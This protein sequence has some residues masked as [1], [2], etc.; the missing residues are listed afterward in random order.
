MYHDYAYKR[1]ADRGAYP[2]FYYSRADEALIDQ[3]ANSTSFTGRVANG[4]FRLKRTFAPKLSESYEDPP[5]KKRKMRQV[6]D[7]LPSNVP[8]GFFPQ[9]E[10]K[11]N[12]P[13]GPVQTGMA[14]PDSRVHSLSIKGWNKPPP[15]NW[16]GP[17]RNH[18]RVVDNMVTTNLAQVAYYG[19]TFLGLDQQRQYIQRVPITIW[20]DEAG[21]ATMSN[22][23]ANYNAANIAAAGTSGKGKTMWY[24]SEKSTIEYR[25]NSETP[26]RFDIA[27]FNYKVASSVTVDQLVLRGTEQWYNTVTPTTPYSTDPKVVLWH[28]PLQ[29][30]GKTVVKKS[31]QATRYVLPG[32]SMLIRVSLGFY[33]D[34]TNQANLLSTF[35][36]GTG[37]MLVRMEG[38]LGHLEDPPGTFITALKAINA[39]DIERETFNKFWKKETVIRDFSL[40]TFDVAPMEVDVEVVN[41]FGEMKEQ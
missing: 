6:D 33:N 25:N 40:T 3:T 28:A 5:R 16:D 13:G 10:S 29:N 22:L 21:V 8:A 4:Y 14:T 30:E 39:V 9:N 34:P 2:L 19:Q 17:W 1:Y 37:Y 27:F 41:Q 36:P 18:Y 32:Q 11:E 7:D 26:V 38:E 15:K 23:Q 20:D 31:F 35:G 12:E 24:F